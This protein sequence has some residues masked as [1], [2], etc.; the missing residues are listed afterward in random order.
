MQEEIREKI[1]DFRL[2]RDKKAFIQ[3][4]TKDQE[5]LDA[6][7]EH[8]WNLSEYP[9]KEY[10][11]WMFIHIL[12]SGEIDGS[13]YY[14]RLV[15]TLFKTDDQTVLRNISVCLNQLKITSYKESDLIDLLIGF[16]QDGSNKVALQVYAIYLLIQFC[17]KYPELTQEIR[18]II[19]LNS[20][21][22]TA[23]F[24]V[25]KRN[26]MQQTNTSNL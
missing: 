17:E 15:D 26:F 25:A 5:H 11:S 1:L 12:Q 2:S 3:Y 10:A 22:K 8:I 16:I 14:K 24:R 23:A 13:P 18:E 9:Y 21:G 19:E 20:E 7:L 6:M 4:F